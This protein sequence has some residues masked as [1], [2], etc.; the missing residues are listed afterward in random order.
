MD[1]TEILEQSQRGLFKRVARAIQGYR[2]SQRTEQT[3]LHWICRF[4]RFHDLKNPEK[5]E[6]NDRILFLDYLKNR[7]RASRARL[8]QAHNALEFFYK[9]VLGKQPL[10]QQAP[11]TACLRRGAF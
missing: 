3:Y 4:I 10:P 2:L 5:L 6:N 11:V 1:I 9:D 8:N 7:I